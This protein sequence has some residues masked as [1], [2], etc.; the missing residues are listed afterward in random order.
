M[1]VD[2]S[3][4]AEDSVNFGSNTV[5][6]DSD[7][8]VTYSALATSTSVQSGA[9]VDVVF[10]LDLSASMCWGTQAQTVTSEEDSRIKAM[11][12]ALNESISVLAQAN[13]ENRIGVAVFNGTGRVLMP[14]T[15]VEGFQSIENNQ[16]FTLSDFSGTDGLDD[17]EATVT[18]NMNGETANTAGG[19]NVQAGLY[20]GM[21]LLAD[22]EETTYTTQNQ[23]VTRIPNVVVMSDGAPTTF[24]S[25]TDAEYREGSSGN[26]SGPRVITNNSDLGNG[27][28]TQV[29]GSWW[30][31][32]D[33]DNQTG[34]IGGGDNYRAHSADG[35]M[36]LATASYMK[37][38]I[39][40]NYYG[41]DG[42]DWGTNADNTANAYTIGFSTDQQTDAM[43]TMANIVL[44]PEENLTA[45]LQ[46]SDLGK[47]EIA[48]MWT[49]A[50]AYLEGLDA[51]VYGHIGSKGNNDSVPD[52]SD[53]GQYDWADMQLRE[54]IAQH[55]TDEDE[56][57]DVTSFSYPTQYFSANDTQGLIDAFGEIA[58][59][60]TSSA[61]APTEV[62]GD[63][64]TDGYITYKD[65]TGQYME[66][67]NVK[68]LIFMD[69]VLDVVKDEN[70][71][72]D[73]R[74]VYVAAGYEY[75]N[76]AYP[77]R[78]FNTNQIGIVVTDNGDNTQTI[79]VNIPAALI[80]LRTNTVTLDGNGDP[81]NNETSETKPLRLCYEVGLAEGVDAAT[82]EGVSEEYIDGNSENGKVSF[83]SNAYTEGGQTNN[84]VGATVEFEPAPTNPFYFIQ[85]D[86]PLYVADSVDADGNPQYARATG[87]LDRGATYYVPI[88]YYEGA[89]STVKEI[90]SY[91][92]RTGET[93]AKYVESDNNGLYIREGS[94]RIGNLQD[95][96]ASKS[97]NETDTYGYYREPVFVYDQGGT[98]PQA[99]HFLV[100]LGNNGKLSV[101]FA[102][103]DVSLASDSTHASIDGQLVGVG[104][105]LHYTINWVNT[106]VDGNGDA[107]A[108]T[109][110]IVDELPSGTYIED[111]DVPEDATY[112]AEAGTLTWT[113]EAA[114]GASGTVGFDVVV[115]P[116]AVDNEDNALPNS[117]TITVGNSV[118][119]TNT[120]VNYV[121]EKSVSMP[122]GSGGT[123]DADGATVKPGTQLTYTI[124]YRNTESTESTVTITDAVP[125]GT[126]F[127]SADPAIQPDQ[128]GNLEWTIDN[129][130]AGATGSVSF[131]VEVDDNAVSTV[132][133]EANVAIGNHDPVVTNKVATKIYSAQPTTAA[134]EVQKTFT[135]HAWTDGYKFQFRIEPVPTTADGVDVADMPMPEPATIT[136]GAPHSGDSNTGSFGKMTFS[137]AGE[138][139]YKITE[140]DDRNDG[141]TCVDSD[142]TVTVNVTEDK[143]AGTLS[144]DIVYENG[145]QSAAFTN[146]YNATFD[147]DTSVTLQG[148]KILDV[149]DG[150]THTLEDGDFAFAITP[151]DGAPAV[152]VAPI[153]NANS[154]QV[155]GTNDWT[156]TISLFD[157]LEFGIANLDGAP[158]KTF[159]YVVAENLPDGV[160]AANPTAAGMTYD[161]AAYKVDITVT[162]DG[163]GT[164]SAFEPV[165]T[166][167][168]WDGSGFTADADQ[169]GVSGVVFTNTY[170]AGA[171]TQAPVEIAKTLNG[172]TPAEGAFTFSMSIASAD[173]Q[174]GVTLPQ[175]H[176]GVA[177]DAS[178]KVQFGEL[179]FSKPGTYVVEVTEDIPEQATNANVNN[180]LTAYENASDEQKAVSG[181]TFKGVSYDSHSVQM[182]YTVKD[183]GAGALVLNSDVPVTGDAAFANTYTATGELTLSGTKTLEGRDW[184]DGDDFTFTLTGKN[185]SQGADEKSGFELPDPATATVDYSAA[186]AAA[187]EGHPTEG[188]KVPFSFG[189][190][191]FSEVGT[192][193]FAIT[194][195]GY[196]DEA[197]VTNSSGTSATFTYSVTDNGDGSLTVTPVQVSQS[198]T[199]DFTNTYEPGNAT[200]GLTAT[201]TVNGE[202][203]GVVAGLFSFKIEAVSAPSGA[204]AALP[205]NA[206][207]EGVV[208]NGADGAIDFGTF[209]F[210]AEGE[211]VYRVTETNDNKPGYAYDDATY[212]IAFR[213]TDDPASG[214]LVASS[215]IH[216]GESLEGAEVEA[217]T[218]ANEYHAEPAPATAA[219]SGT[220]SVTNEH[221][222]FAME[223]G[224]F[225]FAMTNTQAPSGVTAP[226][227]SG[228]STV[229]NGTD[230]SFDFGTLTFTE[231][232]EYR[233]TVSEVIPTDPSK[234][235]DG[236]TYDG[237]QY[238]LY[239]KVVDN[240]GSLAVE[241]QT[242]T[243]SAGGSV[244]AGALNFANIYNDGEVSYQIA[245]TKLLDT[246]GFDG[247]ALADGQFGFVL[248][249]NGQ[250]IQT[251]KNGAP[252]GNGAAFAFEPIVYTQPGTHVY[253]VYEVGV[254]GGSGT[255][256]TD[257][258]NIAYSTESYTV[259]VT[260]SQAE[261]AEGEH[262]GLSVSADVQNKDIVF[263]NEYAP[264]EVTVGSSGDV[265]IGGIKTLDVADGS[266]REMKEGEFTF[267]LLEGDQEIDRAV[268]AAD[269]SFVFGDITYDTVGTHHYTVSEIDNGLGGIDYDTTLYSA[270]IEV[271]ENSATHKLEAKVVY[272]NTAD[273]STPVDKM[274]FANSYSANP[275]TVSLGV[276]KTLEG[277]QLADG[278][279]SFEISAVDGA[280]M[281]ERTKAT[282]DAE[283]RVDFGTIT[284]DAVG[285]YDY[286]VSEV[287]DA[288]EG[289]VYDSDTQRTVHVSVA[290]GGAGSLV[291]RVTYGPNG[292]SFVN[293]YTPPEETEQGDKGEI[294][295]NG[296]KGEGGDKNDTGGLF[297]LAKT[298]DIT[299]GGMAAV[300]VIAIA[301]IG[302]VSCAARKMRNPQDRHLR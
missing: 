70:S 17:G 66:I 89:D 97:A 273:L 219:F 269:G 285:E 207:A 117:A 42:A 68:T 213:V 37:N 239:F 130:A 201:K 247:A 128:D 15:R 64:L 283:G 148:T 176:E 178:G 8:L 212:T 170:A 152:S 108:A 123:A 270:V 155:D 40:A 57:Y 143:T 127:V 198:G 72:T 177:N 238:T 243:S 138:Y 137:K 76:P 23:T 141:T 214:K 299:G 121:P 126:T 79:E 226:T 115:D 266:Q 78:S 246:N 268:N 19:T 301:A 233:Y 131:T 223:A 111:G 14:L 87:E 33:T 181:W 183:G 250:T 165:I 224:Q 258:G 147:G 29:R 245:G 93:L 114:A 140:L 168:T 210:D 199:S 39:S 228:G 98:D 58:S 63:P 248:V 166:K 275:T 80:P 180:G 44:N 129:V 43:A 218:F 92:A 142:Q 28:D 135:G 21:K 59:L 71:S 56:S 161:T 208:T 49:A 160:D 230:G 153:E 102:S 132:E 51:E 133:N 91:V 84:G 65:T 83:Y 90:T 182:T 101:P 286:V 280:P 189:E 158:S 46:N 236:I 2:K 225:S 164:L 191:A 41:K 300:V 262:G 202:S 256:G 96:T 169:S 13:S 167:G 237:T 106:A 105:K 10:V 27:T 104:E 252:A 296:G 292:A 100:L 282:N 197:G 75:S 278:Q 157:G 244:D 77:G 193:E 116:T 291:A 271:T 235:I 120:T 107:A 234:A 302:A 20:Q 279:F 162:D 186:V 187:G 85:E 259:T 163:K 47:G 94:P 251:V 149:A 30:E 192:Y 297:K 156:S 159:S 173:P 139:V 261:G 294:V 99:G 200:A 253:T 264:D 287:S 196:G 174:D 206:T 221:G 82:L 257:S 16:Y 61:S 124:E 205:T 113:I 229:T 4:S 118:Y 86:T 204:T 74:E 67:K 1:W 36:A 38:K 295:D 32:A 265:Q 7:F 60:I 145:Q 254:D 18:C 215:T 289:V 267:L 154:V 5:T 190:I 293:T 175:Q 179:T 35:F 81:T 209:T 263:T 276:A 109:V 298:G 22:E 171:L 110:T 88:T 249:E 122:D 203:E 232:G 151:L 194:E 6:N 260:V 26:W 272:Y 48:R 288:Q 240:Q 25:P 217:I 281:P 144:A 12:D 54:F 242:I 284:Y 62:T 150:L 112:D 220:K 188:V 185:V 172:G 146:T 195:S 184:I 53:S 69:Q 31:P 34:Q 50:Q 55:P 277:G 52:R 136:I 73:G 103:K 24:A 227:P 95:V 290:D 241:T 231:L 119:T 255:G 11:V 222:E 274:T 9:P 216:Q 211:Y 45:D 125:E 134:I 3:V